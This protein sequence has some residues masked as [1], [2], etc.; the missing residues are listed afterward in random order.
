MAKVTLALYAPEE[1]YASGDQ[2]Q[3]ALSILY[4]NIVVESALI[5]VLLSLIKNGILPR[6]FSFHKELNINLNF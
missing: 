2:F 6:C 5:P 1:T 3:V 4:P